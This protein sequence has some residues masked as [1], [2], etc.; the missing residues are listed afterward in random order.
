MKR[1]AVRAGRESQRHMLAVPSRQHGGT[2]VWALGSHLALPLQA[3]GH[4]DRFA[5][6]LM[7]P[8]WPPPMVVNV[9][10]PA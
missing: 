2:V 3:A 10:S 7:V 8:P 5:A 1:K 4:Q 9:E 6:G